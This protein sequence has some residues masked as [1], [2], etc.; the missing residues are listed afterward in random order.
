MPSPREIIADTLIGLGKT[1]DELDDYELADL[2]ISTLDAEGY[3]IARKEP[4]R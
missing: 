2:L 1:F 4:V 3:V